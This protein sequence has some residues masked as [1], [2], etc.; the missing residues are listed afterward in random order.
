MNP[1]INKQTNK[2]NLQFQH[3]LQGE[4]FHSEREERE[5]E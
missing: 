5:M 3:M 4:Y 1:G 2:Q